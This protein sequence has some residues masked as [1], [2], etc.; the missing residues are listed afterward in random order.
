MQPFD[1]AIA[2]AARQAFAA[3]VGVDHVFFNEEDQLSYQD[4]FAVDDALHH[5][6]GA[7]APATVEEIQAILKVA[8]ERKLPLWPISRGKNLGYG[9]RGHQAPHS[10]RKIPETPDHTT[11]ASRHLDLL[12]LINEP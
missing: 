5:P 8:S 6:A 1:P 7:V 10:W 12:A 2:A 9:G 11:N 4:K 3:I